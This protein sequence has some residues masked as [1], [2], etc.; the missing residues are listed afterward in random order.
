MTELTLDLVNKLFRYDKETG[1][2]I[3]KISVRKGAE[4]G[5]IVGKDDGYGYLKTCLLYTSPRQRD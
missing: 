4:A 5:Q 2:L 3:R 1:N